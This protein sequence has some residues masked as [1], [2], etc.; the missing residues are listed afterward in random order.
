VIEIT[1]LGGTEDHPEPMTVKAVQ[2][3]R[4]LAYHKDP[5]NGW[6]SLTHI[7]SGRHFGVQWGRAGELR[8]SVRAANRAVPGLRWDV[9]LRIRSGHAYMTERQKR[10]H[11]ALC[12]HAC[13]Y[14][15]EAVLPL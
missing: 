3:Q 12:Q 11:E 1:I 2:L 7:A 14:A 15:L 5:R 6:W 4:G 10:W 13:G 9:E 8:E